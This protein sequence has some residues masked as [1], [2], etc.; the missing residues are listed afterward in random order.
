MRCAAASDLALRLR[1]FER[2]L[3]RERELRLRLLPT[4]RGRLRHR[5]RSL[6]PSE[7]ALR[8]GEPGVRLRVLCS[9]VRE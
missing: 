4:L 3:A 9:R 8:L 7:I 5:F 1:D 2:P 6:H